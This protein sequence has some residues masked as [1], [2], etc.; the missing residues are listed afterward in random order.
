MTIALARTINRTEI[1]FN[2][3]VNIGGLYEIIRSPECFVCNFHSKYI[4][5]YIMGS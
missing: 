3:S 5:I 4:Y 2:P 1:S